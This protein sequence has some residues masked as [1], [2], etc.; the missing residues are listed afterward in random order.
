M[1]DCVC[2]NKEHIEEAIKNLDYR[3]TIVEYEA[4]AFYR[5]KE[6]Y[7]LLTHSPNSSLISQPIPPDFVSRIKC[8]VGSD[9]DMSNTIT[10]NM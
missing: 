2:G 1:M 3:H 10:S 9:S 6:F 8:I 5:D 4:L 7:D